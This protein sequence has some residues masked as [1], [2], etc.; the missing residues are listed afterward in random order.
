MTYEI[1]GWTVPLV[2]G[3]ALTLFSHYV[4]TR[5][6]GAL[7]EGEGIAA[8]PSRWQGRSLLLKVFGPMIE[9]L[10]DLFS[11]L[12]LGERREKLRKRLLQAGN[13]GGLSPDEFHGARIVASILLLF[14][15]LFLD[16]GLGSTPFVTVLFVG[17][18]L[19]YP[20]LW[21][22]GFIQKRQRKIFRD[23]PDMLDMLRL[24]IEAGLDFGSAMKV[25][26]EKGRKGPLLDELEKVER[27]ISLGRTRAESFRTFADRLQ[28]TEVNAFVLALIQADQLGAS[29]G[30]ILKVQSEVGRQRRWQVA[31]VLVNKLPMKML[32][33]LIT[34]IFPASFIILFTPLAIQ[35][36]QSP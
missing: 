20:D 11:S 3:L 7:A 31:E 23:L 24:A 12:P 32:G 9:I 21:L 27:D 2:M 1:I 6:E 10:G 34:F 4:L 28:M 22:S 36:M 5:N 17:L 33:P 26:V 29:I 30:P 18:G 14:A 19:I 16:D 8:R 25:V 35:Y 15:G 13:P